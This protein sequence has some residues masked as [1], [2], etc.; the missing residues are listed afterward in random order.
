MAL[1]KDQLKHLYRKRAA[2]YDFS[3]NLYYLIGFREESY[4]KSAVSALGLERGDTVV[5]IGRRSFPQK[6]EMRWLSI[7]FV[8]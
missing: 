5:E 1:T 4:R 6:G 3:A 8:E 2:N 7:W